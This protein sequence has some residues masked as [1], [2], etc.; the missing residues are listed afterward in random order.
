MP[1]QVK[2]EDRGKAPTHCNPVLEEDTWSATRFGRFTPGK[3][4]VRIIYEAR[5]VLGPV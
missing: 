2:T 5:W 3:D 1:T 4:Q